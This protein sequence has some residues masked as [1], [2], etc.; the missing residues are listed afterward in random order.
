MRFKCILLLTGLGLIFGPTAGLGGPRGGSDGERG[1]DPGSKAEAEFRQLDTNGDGLLNFDE[2]SADPTLA[3]ERDKWDT[4]KD[5]FIDL[6][7]FKEYFKARTQQD[8]AA[9]Q[10]EPAGGPRTVKGKSEKLPTAPD[11]PPN[12]PDWFKRYDTDGDGQI[13]LYEWKAAGQP[14][15][16]FLALDL[17]GDGFLT[18][19]EVLWVLAAEG[20]TKGRQPRE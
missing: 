2:I 20:A 13:G 19:D 17:N 11:L 9:G 5:G 15:A 16:R 18:A 10:G 14:L 7:E 4:N 12:L 1:L 3:A 6:N 8:H